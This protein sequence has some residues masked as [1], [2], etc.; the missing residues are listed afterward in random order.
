MSKS[1]FTGMV[2]TRN[3]TIRIN[4]LRIT[5][6]GRMHI[7]LPESSNPPSHPYSSPTAFRNG[8]EANIERPGC[9]L[10]LIGTAFIMYVF[11]FPLSKIPYWVLGS[12]FL[13]LGARKS[14]SE[15][16]EARTQ[17]P[18]Y[19]LVHTSPPEF[20]SLL[21]KII[22]ILQSG[23]PPNPLCAQLRRS[24]GTFLD[25]AGPFE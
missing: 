4:A 2:S 8:S 17:S 12:R 18:S 22:R 9:Q 23:C 16:H 13:V 25:P 21:S 14:R 19:T 20:P 11:L 5:V 1:S 24:A 6:K 3:R 7:S 15:V 10:I